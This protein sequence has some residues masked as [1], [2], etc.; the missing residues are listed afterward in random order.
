MHSQRS[1]V[2]L[3]TIIAC[4]ALQQ[5]I[6]GA[7]GETHCIIDQCRCQYIQS[8][9]ESNSQIFKV[10][11]GDFLD[12]AHHKLGD[13]PM[14]PSSQ[15]PSNLS[16]IELHLGNNKLTQVP[17]GRLYA[18]VQ[19]MFIKILDLSFNQITNV[20]VDAFKDLQGVAVLNLNRN[21]LKTIDAAT[22]APLRTTV[23][24]ID[25]PR[26]NITKIES[27]TFAN[28]SKLAYLN[29]GFNQIA[30]INSTA[31]QH[32]AQL[33]QLDLSGN[34]LKQIPARLFFSL[35]RLQ[36]INLY[37]QRSPHLTIDDFAFERDT[38]SND[39]MSAFNI[40]LG[41][42]TQLGTRSFCSRRFNNSNNNTRKGPFGQIYTIMVFEVSVVNTN[43]SNNNTI[44]GPF[45]QIN[46]I[47]VY[48]LG[49]LN[50]NS[51]KCLFKQL[52]HSGVDLHM[53]QTMHNCS[54]E[55]LSIEEE[56]RFCEYQREMDC[57]LTTTAT[58]TSTTK[59]SATLG[60][61]QASKDITA[62]TT[63]PI[64]STSEL[65]TFALLFSFLFIIWICL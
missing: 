64:A 59:T 8:K 58:T 20:H 44:K 38:S 26:N 4:A 62:T 47:A 14:R 33:R 50:I 42:Q 35:V 39:Q 48:N 16:E 40:T 46:K 19:H 1:A 13:L 52:E 60:T 27:L 5:F 31:F 7:A 61:I 6:R 57:Q 22:L 53:G 21:K 49:V 41:N 43:N 24:R 36:F 32:S 37:M 56:H 30:T 29:L 9:S 3:L 23:E 28:F 17:A 34:S 11:C 55:T 12:S 65:I 25:L 18:L 54:C 45:G 10:D 63:A 15:Y 51:N 2:L